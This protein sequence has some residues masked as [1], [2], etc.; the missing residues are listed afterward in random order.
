MV[1][2][3]TVGDSTVG[4]VTT[5]AVTSRVGLVF[6]MAGSSAL[7]ASSRGAMRTTCRSDAAEY[8]GVL[9]TQAA[10]TSTS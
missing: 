9:P 6:V 1:A 8:A 2:S 4:S 3:S 10:A 5:A 7:S